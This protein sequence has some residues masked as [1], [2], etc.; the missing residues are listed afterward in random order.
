MQEKASSPPGDRV[1]I[2][3]SAGVA[4]VTLNRPDKLNALDPAMFEAIIAAGEGLSRAPGL[5]AVVLSGAGRGFCAGLD[6]ETFAA[7]AAGRAPGRAELMART[8]GLAN[9]WQQAAHVWRMLPVPVIAAIH[10]V[11]LGGGFQIALGAD[12]RYVAPDARLSILEIKWGLVPDMA[13]IALMRELARS[14]VIRELAMT[15]RVFSG[16]EALAYGFATSLH[17]DPLAAARATA[18][19]IAARSPDAVRAVKRLLNMASDAD[20]AAILLAESKEQ[21]ALIGS[22]NQIEAVRAG[23]EGRAGRFADG[24]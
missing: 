6:K 16:A 10:G 21:A 8:H 17:A 2:D 7:T 5:R 15:G 13:G 4:E 19:E 14:D 3:V 12:I 18:K 1:G 11:A 20:A 24:G 9:A 22:P 23:V